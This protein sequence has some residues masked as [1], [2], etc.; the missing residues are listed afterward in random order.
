ME[1]ENIKTG[2]SRES[3]VSKMLRG[4]EPVLAATDY[5]RA[6]A[7]QIRPYLD[8][9]YQVLGTD[10]FGRSDTRKNL[11]QFFNIDAQSILF[12]AMRQLVD[13][14]KADETMLDEHRKRFNERCQADNA[15]R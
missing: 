14:K 10:G 1:K 2:E 13:S 12:H 15:V 3:F 8:C 11:R 4:K 9:P 5:V 7:E 6:Y